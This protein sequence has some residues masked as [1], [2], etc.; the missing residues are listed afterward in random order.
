MKDVVREVEI[1]GIH[2]LRV[3]ELRCSHLVDFLER[4]SN[5]S[6][7]RVGLD[8]APC[9]GMVALPYYVFVK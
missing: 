7:R 4:G 9:L 3:A 6:G 5:R 1:H 2:L 8:P